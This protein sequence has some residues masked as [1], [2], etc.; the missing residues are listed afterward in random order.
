MLDEVPFTV[1]VALEC[2]G[3]DPQPSRDGGPGGEVGA[4]GTYGRAP[5]IAGNGRGAHDS[6]PNVR[7]RLRELLWAGR[8]YKAHRIAFMIAHGAMPDPPHFVLHDGDKSDGLQPIH[9]YPGTKQES[10]WDMVERGCHKND[11]EVRLREVEG[12]ERAYYLG[13]G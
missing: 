13:R 9:L 5:M 8:P 1:A 11:F 3:T 10:S 7:R 2:S 4:S 12:Q 6:G